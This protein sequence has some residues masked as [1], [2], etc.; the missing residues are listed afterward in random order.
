MKTQPHNSALEREQITACLEQHLTSILK[1]QPVM[2]AYLYGSVAERNT[3]QF[4]DVDI[5]LV[6]DPVFT[7]SAYE[8]L[9]VA[10]TVAEDIEQVC[11]LPEADVRTIDNAPLSLQGQVLTTGNLLYS[12]D[13]EFRVE[14]EVAV[15]KRYLDFLPVQNMLQ[16]AFFE[17]VSQEGLTGG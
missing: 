3:T 8:H 5:A 15:R 11:D 2:L 16:D 7:G 10:F 14:Y 13:E 1:E 6:L 4:S 12:R 9:Q 17:Q